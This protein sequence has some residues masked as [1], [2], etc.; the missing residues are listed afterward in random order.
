MES[1]LVQL[2]KWHSNNATGSRIPFVIHFPYAQTTPR[3]RCNYTFSLQLDPVT[4]VSLSLLL[5]GPYDRP[6]SPRPLGVADRSRHG[7]VFFLPSSFKIPETTS[8]RK[9]GSLVIRPV[10]KAFVLQHHARFLFFR[11]QRVVFMVETDFPC[12]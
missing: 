4:P 7:Y 2:Y 6:S 1:H 11:M 8:L 12:S 9:A 5:A 10:S 3:Q